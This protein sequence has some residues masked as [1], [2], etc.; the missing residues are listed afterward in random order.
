MTEDGPENIKEEERSR[1]RG[2][3]KKI[4]FNHIPPV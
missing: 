1:E 4:K 2:G 3:R